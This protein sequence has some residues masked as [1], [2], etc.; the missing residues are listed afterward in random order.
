MKFNEE[1][2]IIKQTYAEEKEKLMDVISNQQRLLEEKD[3]TIR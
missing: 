2:N 3:F 1:I